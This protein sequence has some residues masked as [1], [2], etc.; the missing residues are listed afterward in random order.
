MRGHRLPLVWLGYSLG[1]LRQIRSNSVGA[2]RH[3]DYIDWSCELEAMRK[4]IGPLEGLPSAFHGIVDRYC[5]DIFLTLT[6]ISRV[7]R[8]GGTATFIVGNSCIRGF[9]IRNADALAKAAKLLGFR[10]LSRRERELPARY[11]YLPIR[12]KAHLAR[13]CAQRPFS[14][15]GSS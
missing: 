13:E 9:F 15:S 12:R 11:R 3:P 10:Q 7:L 14:G 1:T 8:T 4:S 6:E 2:E 5:R